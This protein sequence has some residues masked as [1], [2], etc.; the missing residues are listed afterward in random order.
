M[1]VDE[2]EDTIGLRGLR[3]NGDFHTVAGLV[4]H[5]LGH[6]PVAG[7]VLYRWSGQVMEPFD[8]LA[9]IGRDP[10][11]RGRVFVVT[12]DSG[13]GMTHGTLA[14]LL[15]CELV[16][17]HDHPWAALYDPSRKM[18]RTLG[19]YLRE[20]LDAA[21]HLARAAFGSS[22]VESEDRLRPGEGAIMKSFGRWRSTATS[23]GIC[24][25]CRRSART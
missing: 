25:G 9:F 3:G 2:F 14:A 1:P 7:E 24:T 5:H 20:N 21:R 4:L 16:H 13:M 12:G 19:T 15:L 10:A 18:I 17:G 6:V 23:G 11:Y 8:G 22:D